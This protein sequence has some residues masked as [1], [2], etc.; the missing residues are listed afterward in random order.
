[1]FLFK[2]PLLIRGYGLKSANGN[3]ACD[4][5]TFSLHVIDVMDKRPKSERTLIEV[6]KAEN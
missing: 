3:S 4:P 6:H 1:M 2:R 5:K